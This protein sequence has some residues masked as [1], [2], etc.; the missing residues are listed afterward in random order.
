[1]GRADAGSVWLHPTVVAAAAAAAAALTPS[2]WAKGWR[3]T[4]CVLI[5][6]C[7]GF[8]VRRSIDRNCI[9]N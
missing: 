7:D 1:M 4:P 9:S 5:T 8:V 2:Q 3:I 6:R